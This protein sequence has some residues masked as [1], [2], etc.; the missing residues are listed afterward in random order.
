[1]TDLLHAEDIKKAVGAFTCEQR[2]PLRIPV[3]SSISLAPAPPWV[4]RL[5]SLP[6]AS[7]L[8]LPPGASGAWKRVHG[9]TQT[10]PRQDLAQTA[11]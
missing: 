8:T 6:G 7:M 4:P 3:P 5:A 2:A 1:M 10:W 9:T 11:S